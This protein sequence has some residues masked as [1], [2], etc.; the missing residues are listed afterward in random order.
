MDWTLQKIELENFKFFKEPFELPVGG[1]HVLLYGENF[2]GQRYYKDVKVRVT[3]T[4]TVAVTV[5]EYESLRQ[6]F[7]A[8]CTALGLTVAPAIETTITNNHT[9]TALT[10]L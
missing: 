5:Q 3:S 1:K 9:G 4:T 10:L 6:V 7:D 8:V 2:G